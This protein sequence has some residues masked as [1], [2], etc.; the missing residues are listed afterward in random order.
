MTN[1]PSL[2]YKEDL[3][4][5]EHGDKEWLTTFP[6]RQS[7]PETDGHR[8]LLGTASTTEATVSPMKANE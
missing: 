6:K 5:A 8:I 4:M 3:A 2:M 7:D 1:R